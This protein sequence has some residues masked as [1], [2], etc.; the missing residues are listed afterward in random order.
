MILSRT[1]L[2]ISFVGGSTDI[3]QFYENNEYGCVIST[4]IDQYVYIGVNERFDGGIRLA[5]SKN[6]VVQNIKEIENDRI[7]TAF[8]NLDISSGIEV[9]YCRIKNIFQISV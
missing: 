9:F 2:R 3:P 5:Y 6:E 1:P 8:K 4:S 7:Q